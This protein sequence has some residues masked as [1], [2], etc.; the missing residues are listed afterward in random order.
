MCFHA[1]NVLTNKILLGQVY[2]SAQATGFTNRRWKTP[3]PGKRQ[4]SQPQQKALSSRIL[5][6]VTMTLCGGDGTR[7]FTTAFPGKK[8]F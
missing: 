4:T 3:S 8:T 7:K 1:T 5:S 6:M 2:F